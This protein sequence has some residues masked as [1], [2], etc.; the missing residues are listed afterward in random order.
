MKPKIIEILII[1]VVLCLAIGVGIYGFANSSTTFLLL[2]VFIGWLAFIE[3]PRLYV[4]LSNQTNWRGT[5][6]SNANLWLKVAFLAS[7]FAA[8]VSLNSPTSLVAVIA[9]VFGILALIVFSLIEDR[10]Q[11]KLRDATPLPVGIANV[12]KS[13]WLEIALIALLS[14]VGFALRAYDLDHF[15]L[16]LHGDEAESAL[17]GI[18]ILD[19]KDPLPPFSTD[20][21]HLPTLYHYLEAGFMLVFGRTMSGVRMASAVFGAIAIP[22]IYLIGRLGWSRGAGLVAAILITFSHTHIHYSR[23]GGGYIHPGVTI[24][25]MMFLFALIAVGHRQ[26]GIFVAIGLM[27]GL[28]LYMYF[29]AR[30]LP[31]V[32]V[33]L[34]GYLLWKKTL[35][36]RQV[37]IIVSAILISFF[38]QILFYLFSPDKIGGRTNDVFVFTETNIRHVIGNSNANLANSWHLII[39]NQISRVFGYFINIGD[40]GGK[41]SADF[42]GFDIITVVLCWAGL[43]FTIIRALRYHEF[44]ILVWFICGVSIGGLL[45]IDAPTGNRLMAVAPAF[46]VFG[47]IF[48]HYVFTLFWRFIPKLLTRSIQTVLVVAMIVGVAYINLK[49]V[50]I[51]YPFRGATAATW[52]GRDLKLRDPE[53][54]RAYI[55]A[56]P[57]F[58]ADYS[59]VKFIALNM[60]PK[61][62]EKLD[63]LKMSND[64]KDTLIYV[65]K[66]NENL[67]KSVKAK[68][69]QGTET[70]FKDPYDR[71]IYWLYRIPAQ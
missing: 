48:A 52:V 43:I 38:P 62:I 24:T 59:T 33:V 34:V 26:T 30:L 4:N 66:Q 5:I 46:Y 9:W 31:I 35:N 40:G 10:S 12:L 64:G 70:E 49:V 54:E 53:K 63:D 7:V 20:W 1:S 58:Y 19:W 69:P 65:I 47:G 22:F 23:M 8:I 25:L 39:F 32:A 14:L 15:P 16:N 29:S 36:W 6:A 68:Y 61:N 3:P 37:G 42:P 50:F 57:I 21:Y 44:S 56:I 27:I 18:R 55:M 28:S 13:H 60:H 45:T 11:I 67:Y 41:Y 71:F 51:D 17:R 2:A